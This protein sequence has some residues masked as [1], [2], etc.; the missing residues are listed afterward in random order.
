MYTLTMRACSL[1]AIVLIAAAATAGCGTS[2]KQRDD[3]AKTVTVS[4]QW[5]KAADSG[6]TGLFGTFKNSGSH[7]ARIVSATSP[8]AGKVE[9]HE[10]VAQPGGASTMRPKE[11]GFVIPAEGSHTLAPGA[12]H[13]M[14]MDLKQPLA[15]GSDVDVTVQFEDG[16]SLPFTAQV[17]EFRG[18]VEN[19]QPG[20]PGSAGGNG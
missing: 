13:V 16:S 19:Y 4:D 9:L 6:M 7:E 18:A 12:D 17:R 5:V 15:V 1:G 14:L 2:D 20:G 3:A 8:V 10:V 11:G